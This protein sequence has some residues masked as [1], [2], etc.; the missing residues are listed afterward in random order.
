[1]LFTA[2][3]FAVPALSVAQERPW[4][5]SPCELLKHPGMYDETMVSVPGLVLYGGRNSLPIAMIALT[6]TGF[7]AWSLEA[8]PPTQKINF[9]CP[10]RVWRRALSL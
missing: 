3:I 7:C 6:N 2:Y 1:M 9:A 5:V 8:I 10:R 4:S